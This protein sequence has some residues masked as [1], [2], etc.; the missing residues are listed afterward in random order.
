MLTPGDARPIA[1]EEA[2]ALWVRAFRCASHP[3]ITGP[4]VLAVSGG[5]DSMAMLWLAAENKVELS[6]LGIEL[7]VA[8]IDHGLRE[9]AIHEAEEVARVCGALGLPH[10]TLRWEGEKPASNLQGAARRARYRLLEAAAEAVGAAAVLTAHH[11]DDQIETHLLARGRHAGDRG[12]AAMRPRRALAPGLDLLRPFLALPGRRMRLTAEASGL[13]FFDDPSNDDDRF[14]RV[15]LRGRV[16]SMGEGERTGRMAEIAGHRRATDRADQ[17]VA[18][19]L[20]ESL[21]SVDDFGRVRLE[22]ER[23]RDRPF[24]VCAETLGRVLAAVSGGEHMPERAALERLC[25]ELARTGAGALTLGGVRVEPGPTLVFAREYG[26]TGPSIVPFNRQKARALFDGRFDVS[27]GEG[28]GLGEP[29]LEG[30]HLV[31]FGRLG[32]GNAAERTLP[33][34]M[35]EG[36]TVLAAPALLA[37]K[38]PD[39]S[40]RL[41]IAG[42]VSWRL[43]ADLPRG[44]RS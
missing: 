5:P 44:R 29:G 1:L 40:R 43:W 37:D 14:D 21:A 18:E 23:F 17:L 35:G 26:R 32:R 41:V 38:L 36:E 31:P 3:P 34:L 12:L 28:G 7:H 22:A 33:I 13:P 19:V 4:V 11:Q 42:R 27:L 24:D 8:T 30:A 39:V 15:R 6:R 16:R 2:L 25:R 10:R 20:K 9:A